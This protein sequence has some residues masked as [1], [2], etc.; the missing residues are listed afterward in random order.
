M[1]A[2]GNPPPNDPDLMRVVHQVLALDRA[3][4]G[5]ASLTDDL[6][7]AFRHQEASYRD[8]GMETT[9]KDR[10]ELVVRIILKRTWDTAGAPAEP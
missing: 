7:E 2:P 9:H 10:A 1:P 5:I 8:A 3:G 4:L 6:I